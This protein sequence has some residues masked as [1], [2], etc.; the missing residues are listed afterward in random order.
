MTIKELLEKLVELKIPE[1]TYYRH[2]VYGSA[3]DRDK[4]ALSINIGKYFIEYEVYFRERI[5][6]NS[7]KIFINETDACK[8]ILKQLQKL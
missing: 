4:I 1:N 8:Y 7:I 2:G 3:N 5:E 6:K